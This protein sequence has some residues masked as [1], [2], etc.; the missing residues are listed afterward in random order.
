[1]FG[2]EENQE[3]SPEV[4][5]EAISAP[6]DHACRNDPEGMCAVSRIIAE[7]LMLVKNS[8]Y[9]TCPA[10]TPF[11]YGGFCNSQIRKNVYDKFNV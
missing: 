8:K 3:V 11:G 2:K 5:R 9:T 6:G 7:R 10:Y 4:I 1:M